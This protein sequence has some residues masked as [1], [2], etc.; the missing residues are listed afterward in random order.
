[1]NL[2]GVYHVSHNSCAELLMHP[3]AASRIP[4][5]EVPDSCNTVTS[6]SL[7]EGLAL[8][9]PQACDSSPSS[10]CLGTPCRHTKVFRVLQGWKATYHESNKYTCARRVTC[11]SLIL[12]C[13]PGP[14]PLTPFGT[15][16][17]T[18][19]LCHC[20]AFAARQHPSY[21]LTF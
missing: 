11:I 4:T 8:V 12:I 6:S 21:P 17:R 3:V 2:G 15:A 9:S 13:P 19:I 16:P 1:M 10:V 14:A 20:A 18:R 5:H 7:F